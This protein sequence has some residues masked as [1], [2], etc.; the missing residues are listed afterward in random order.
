MDLYHLSGDNG[1]SSRKIAFLHLLD[2]SDKGY[3][4]G[5]TDY[6]MLVPFADTH[7]LGCEERAWLAYLYALSYSQTTAMV[8]FLALPHY[9]ASP[10]SIRKFWSENKTRLWFNPDRKYIKNNDQFCEA[11]ASLRKAAGE[12]GLYP[13]VDTCLGYGFD[14]LYK[15]IQKNWKFFGPHGAYLFFDAIH[16]LAPWL[17]VDPVTLDWKHCG[18]TV[19]EGMAHLLYQDELIH[20]REF[21]LA[22]YNRTVDLIQSKCDQPKIIIESTL[23]AFRKLF[24]GTRYHGYYAD[25]MLEECYFAAEMGLLP[26]VDLWKL[27]KQTIPKSLRG[28]TLGWSGIRKERN[29]LWLTEGIKL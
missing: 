28:E 14:D 17:S 24:K 21:P 27:R 10:K 11:I 23:C 8:A 3:I 20:T 29:K 15:E 12:E 18:K 7:S 5:A 2:S 22:K 26:E 1:T 16:G 13:Y 9:C 6:C 19:V 25:R 4:D